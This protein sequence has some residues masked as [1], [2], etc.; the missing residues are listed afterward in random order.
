MH[1]HASNVGNVMLIN[2]HREGRVR[3]GHG[4]RSLRLSA[5]P[6]LP[7]FT[8]H[9]SLP[10]PASIT[11]CILQHEGHEGHVDFNQEQK[12]GRDECSIDYYLRKWPERLARRHDVATI[13]AIFSQLRSDLN[14]YLRL[15]IAAVTKLLAPDL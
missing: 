7:L 3:R 11:I 15:T 1:I 6:Y 13:C 12:T 14:L 4:F 9:A 2:A 8:F 10:W 5:F